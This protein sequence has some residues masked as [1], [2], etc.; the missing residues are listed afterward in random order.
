MNYDD[1]N[2]KKTGTNNKQ[3]QQQRVS[4]KEHGR[5]ENA[6]RICCK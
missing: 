4:G 3:Q 1:E 5:G 6:K 2:V